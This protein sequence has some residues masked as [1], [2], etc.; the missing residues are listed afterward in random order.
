LLS[1]PPEKLAAKLFKS[2]IDSREIKEIDFIQGLKEGRGSA[3]YSIA[4]GAVADTLKELPVGEFFNMA[5]FERIVYCPPKKTRYA[6]T[7]NVLSLPEQTEHI[8][9]AHGIVLSVR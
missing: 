7:T 5:D 8:L 9:H 4:R 6:K 2:Y 1:L 3:G